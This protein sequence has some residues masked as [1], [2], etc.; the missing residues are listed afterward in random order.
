MADQPNPIAEDVGEALHPKIS[1][2]A[3][4]RRYFLTGIVVTA[5]IAITL[6]VT[7]WFLHYIDGVVTSLIPPEYNI[8]HIL[9][10]EIPGMG[11]VI[12]VVFFI[13]VGWF[14]RNFL[15]KLI[16]RAS[17]FIVGR[18]PIISTVYNA[19][20]QVLDMTIGD[21]SK[22]FRDVVLFQY[23]RIGIWSMG[24]VTG[25]TRG[26]VQKVADGEVMNVYIPGTPTTAGCLL[27]I[28]KKDLTYLSMT[29][30]EAVKLIVSGGIITPPAR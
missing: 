25:T 10:F 6:W 1:M 17:E 9:P 22:A 2:G 24:F 21:Q 16:I 26:D 7:I 14:A 29:I 19:L 12:A 11:L 3:R 20:K 5:P 28:P 13:V 8:N 18:M 27:F 15:G 30:E 23:P 4:L